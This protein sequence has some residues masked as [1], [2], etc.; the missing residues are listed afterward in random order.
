MI[1]RLALTLCIAAGAVTIGAQEIPS[2]TITTVAGTGKARFDNDNA[3]ATECS[4]SHP[5]AVAVDSKGNLYI[6]DHNNARIR[7]VSHDGIMTTIMGT[8][9]LVET[10]PPAG[11]AKDIPLARAYG[12]A[13]DHEDNLYV[14]SRGQS[15]IYKVTPDGMARVIAGNGTR[16]FGGDGGPATEAMIAWSNHLVADKAGNL[17]IADSGNQRIRKIDKMGI[18][19]TIAGTGEDGFSGDGGPALE[20]TMTGGSAI[21]IDDAGN[22]YMA[23]FENHRIRKVSTDGIMSTIAGTGEPKFN[24]DGLPALESNI[25]EPCGVAV[26]SK[27]YVY[28]GDQINLR[29][30]VVTPSGTM[31]TV[32]GTGQ[33]GR[34]GDGG[35]ATAARIRNPDIITFDAEDNLYFPDNQNNLIRKLTRIK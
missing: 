5:T 28:I 26:D 29:V 20:A 9:E 23:D 11:P 33:W 17:F 15:V 2:F 16:G 12:I 35:P 19:T 8:G 24:G 6:A 34:T 32:A 18:I 7:K 1:G 30:R 22:L 3:L 25:G 10:V 21:D 14:A 4:I 27:G 13:V 31:H